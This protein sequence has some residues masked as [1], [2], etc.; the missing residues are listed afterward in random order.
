MVEALDKIQLLHF[1]LISYLLSRVFVRFRLPERFVSWLFEKK[2]VSIAHLVA[3][4][5]GSTALL[6]MLIPNVITLLAVLPVLL[7]IQSDF[8]GDECAKRR[9][10]T[11]VMLA[12]VWGANIGGMGLIT[13][14]PTNGVLVGMLQSWNLPQSG[15]FT[16]ISWMAW[17]L[18]LTVILCGI[19]WLVLLLVFQPQSRFIGSILQIRDHSLALPKQ[20][21]WIGLSLALVFV[22]SAALLSLAMTSLKAQR[23]IVYGVTLSWT[24]GFLYLF[25]CQR[26]RLSDTNTKDTLLTVKD[27][28]QDPPK[29]GLLWIAIGL[30]LTG[31]LYWLGVPQLVAGAAVSWIRAEHSLF[32]LILVIGLIVTFSTE[33]VSNSMIQL[34]LFVTLLP[35][36]KLYPGISW[37]LMLTV[38]LCSTCAFMSPLATP[39]NGLGYGSS[40][41]ISL[42]Y[43]LLAGLAMNLASVVLITLWARYVVPRVLNWFA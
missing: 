17:A 31:I 13:G 8:E 7:L 2:Q 30:A 24:L 6:S 34:A 25:F 35:L 4:I 37:Q 10:S 39:S 43:M 28:L 11:L 20:V 12:G 5:I 21:K 16:F 9:F 26:F 38:T 40:K 27:I 32:L 42:K 23:W 29:R 1:F 36:S 41:H 3:I 33:L 19:G 15:S 14:T 22:L 18:P